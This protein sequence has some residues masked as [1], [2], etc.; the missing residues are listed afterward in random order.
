MDLKQAVRTTLAQSDFIVNAYLADLTPKEM[1]ARTCPGANHIAWQVGHLIQSER[2]LVDKVAPGRMDSLPEG[3]DT[4]H[5]KDA[6]AI[7]DAGKFLS[8]DEYLRVAKQVREQTL[9]V[10]DSMQPADFDKPVSGVPPFCKTA[11]DVM[12]FLGSHWLMHAG[13]WSSTRRSIG[14]PPLF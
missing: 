14:K 4:R 7:D 12:L 13:Q 3:F 11:G 9:R 1:M 8:K 5:K 2:Y 10:L 6:A